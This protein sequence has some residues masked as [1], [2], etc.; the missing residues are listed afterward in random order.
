MTL[1]IDI[2]TYSPVDLAKCGVYKY[3]KHPDF[4]ILLFGYSWNGGPITVLEIDEDG[5]VDLPDDVFDALTDP[6]VLKTAHNA[7]FERVC[8]STFYGIDMPVE[9][10]ECS[11]IKCAML[12]LPLAL[13]Q[14]AK[15]LRLPEQKMAAG[16][17]LI[18]YF[19]MPC[20]PTKTN[21]GRTRN[22]PQHD[23]GK[24]DLFKTYN[25]LDVEVEQAERKKVAFFEIPDKE[26]ELYCLDQRINDRGVMID[27]KLVINAIR[28]NEEYTGKLLEEATLITGLSNANSVKQLKKWLTEET[29]EEV[30]SLSKGKIPDMIKATDDEK[31]KRLLEIRQEASKTSVK[32]YTAMLASVCSDLR[33]RGLTQFYGANR[34]G[35]FSGRFV[36]LQN[37]PQN[38]LADLDLA[39]QLVIEG[40]DDMLEM[41]FGNVPDTLSQLI[42]TAFIA[43]PGDRFIVADFSAIEARI[44]AWLAGESWVL[45]VFR[46][47]G[48]IYEASAAMMFHVPFEEVTKG[49]DYRKRGK[50]AV[51]ALGFQGGVTALTKM[52]KD[53]AIPDEEKPGIVKA[54]R[55]ANPH[56]VR[57]WYDVNN[58]AIKAVETGERV[59]IKQK[60]IVFEVKHNILFVTLPSGRKL[61]YLRPRIGTNRF[62][63]KSVT[64][65]GMGQETKKWC[66]QETY[67]GKLT[68]NIVQA[69]ARDI[70]CV[71]M[72]RLDKAGY[73]IVF[74]VHDEAISEMPEGKGSVKEMCE[75]MAQ[76]ISWAEG[77]PLR[78]EGYETKYYKKD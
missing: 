68:E 7:A 55:A 63:G 27:R 71:S 57:L 1:G 35:R 40:D 6:D 25:G 16:K 48:K 5:E 75:I 11:M 44:I 66:V 22:F 29:G 13:G 37:L 15:V 30:K 49:S 32:K 53:K 28:I 51:L 17:A 34:T 78:A 45:D 9:Q 72:L 64:Y 14:V 24:W 77:L 60:G 36:Q 46:T 8:L 31:V 23:P 56:I 74:H 76:P 26:K 42:R 18:R 39:R 54:Y 73:P 10:W 62:D 38:H 67:G 69:I 47:H 52:D 70:L 12:G 4:R 2:E 65:E 50:V 3:A 19:C 43:A 61:S 41:L 33:I 21:G 20:K 58:A 59:R